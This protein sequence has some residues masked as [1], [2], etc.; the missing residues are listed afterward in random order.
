M[1]ITAG[2]QLHLVDKC[3]YRASKIQVTFCL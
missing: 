1:I 3:K 2:S